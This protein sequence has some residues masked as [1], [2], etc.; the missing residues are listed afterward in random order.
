MILDGKKVANELKENLFKRIDSLKKNK[1]FPSLSIVLVGNNPASQMYSSFLT[2]TVK[3]YGL[4]VRVHEYSESILENELV[5][6]IK[7]LNEDKT[8]D[9]ILIMMPLPKHISE[10]KIIDTILPEKDI[11]GL[12]TVNI[13]SIVKNKD[14]LCPCTPKA[15]MTILESYKIDIEGKDVVVLGR[16]AVVGKTLALML[17]NKNA[18]VTVCHSKTRNLKDKTLNADILISAIG[19]PHYVKEDMVKKDAIVIDVGINKL[20]GKTVGDVDYEKV[21]KTARAITPV[22]SGVGSVTTT[23][24]VDTLVSVVEKKFLHK[25][26]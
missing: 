24:V 12:T 8:V 23:V 9:G 21:E 7:K 2:K 20:N 13:G 22:P 6:E 19:K 3:K 11:D 5:L 17:L 10:E 15:V 1:I 14:C 25:K 4:D 16:S 18:T 26:G